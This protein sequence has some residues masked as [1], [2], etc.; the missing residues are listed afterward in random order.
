MVYHALGGFRTLKR[1]ELLRELEFFAINSLFIVA[2]AASFTGMVASVQSAYQIRGI[3][4][5]DLL[6]A[7]VGKMITVEL[8]PVLTALILAGRVGASIASELASMKVTE[9]LDA[10]EVM[11]F[12]PER[13][14]VFPKIL[15]GVIATPLLT[16]FSEA[17]ALLA[18][19][20]ISK[21]T[22]GLDFSVFF[23]SFRDFFYLRDLLGGI[24]KG[25][26]FGFLI[27][28]VSSYT[29]IKSREG[30]KGVGRATM[31]AVIYSSVAV[32]LFDYIVGTIFYG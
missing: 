27:T 21:V 1:E 6:G 12:D 3:L 26:I 5:L 18:S 15:S 31:N 9:Q 2:L 17:V 13:F 16:V 14:L 7:G 4:P 30:A 28:S 29:G 23:R 25:V 19:V 32:L 10:M 24:T 8:G 22:L 20:F 11:G